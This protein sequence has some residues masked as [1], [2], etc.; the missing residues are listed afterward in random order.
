MIGAPLET[1]TRRL[2]VGSICFLALFLA[3]DGMQIGVFKLTETYGSSV[4]FGIVAALPS[5]V[6]AYIM[7][8]FCFGVA[9]LVLLRFNAFQEP[10]P[11]RIFAISRYGGDLLKQSYSETIRNLELLKGAFVA[12]L[13]LAIGASLE[14]PNMRGHEMVIVLAAVSA[15]SLSGLSLLFARKAV[16]RVTRIS[17]VAL[18]EQS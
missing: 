13:L 15:I 4:T 1:I 14:F 8:V 10:S 2:G 17:E 5:A 11:E 12:F 6:V 18:Y 16:L 3:V 7:G 9:D